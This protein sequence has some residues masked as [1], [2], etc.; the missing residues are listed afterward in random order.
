MSVPVEKRAEG[1]REDGGRAKEIPLRLTLE[2]VVARCV[3]RNIGL[4]FH[5]VVYPELPEREAKKAYRR[6]FNIPKDAR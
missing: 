4:G 1:S 5:R 2:A 3:N 6:D